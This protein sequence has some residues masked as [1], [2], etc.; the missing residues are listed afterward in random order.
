MKRLFVGTMLAGMST[1]AF[2]Q[3][4]PFGSE[5]DVAYAAS[6]WQVM[7]DAKLAGDGAIMS[8][9]YEGVEPH[10]LMLET[11]YTSAT[12]DGHTGALVVKRNYMP[13]GVSVDEVLGN[14]AEH[15]DAFTIMFRREDG[16]DPETGN[17]FW[18][19]YSPDGTLD[20]NPAGV[21]LAGLVG[22]GA[23]AGCIPCHTGA[24]EDML[25]TTDAALN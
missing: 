25:F 9:P 24:G 21:P 2:A 11:F 22:K 10:G 3:D 15:L 1:M 5:A 19:K 6:L 4:A 16:Y 23:E 18:A 17:W 8:F 20:Q 12:V 14:T 13:A 7:V